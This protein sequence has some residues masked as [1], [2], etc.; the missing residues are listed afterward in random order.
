LGGRHDLSRI[1]NELPSARL[2]RH[3]VQY[4]ARDFIGLLV[5]REMAGVEQVDFGARQ[6]PPERFGARRGKGGVVRAPTPPG[7]AA[8]ARAVM[9]ATPDRMRRW[10]DS[11][12]GT[13]VEIF[14]VGVIVSLVSAGLLRN[15]RFMPARARV[16]VQAYT[17]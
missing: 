4:Q 12:A 6:V 7:S 5:E 10:C 3:K 2:L 8:G 13:F 1:D 17:H 14:P 16:G 11:R 15:S 9:P